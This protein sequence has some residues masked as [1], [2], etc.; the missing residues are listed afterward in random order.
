MSKKIQI[1]VSD[2]MFTWL[3]SE[4]KKRGTRNMIMGNRKILK[5]PNGI[6][7]G[8]PGSGKSFNV[9]RES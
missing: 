1:T 8:V 9:K 7:I 6:I 4:S 2:D 5:N 3:D